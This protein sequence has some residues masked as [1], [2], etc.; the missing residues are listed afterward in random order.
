MPGGSSEEE[1]LKDKPAD[2]DYETLKLITVRDAWQFNN[3]MDP[4]F[5]IF[6]TS[7]ATLR[8]C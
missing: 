4:F 5:R 7:V 8:T 1:D 2:L 3:N 6:G